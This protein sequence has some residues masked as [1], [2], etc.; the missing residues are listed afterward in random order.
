[1][2]GIN[3]GYGFVSSLGNTCTNIVLISDILSSWLSLMLKYYSDLECDPYK[4]DYNEALVSHK[5]YSV[6]CM[7]WPQVCNLLNMPVYV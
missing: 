7:A 2:L 6:P 5:V 4:E 1:M 3:V